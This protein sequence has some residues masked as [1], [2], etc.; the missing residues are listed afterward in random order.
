[1]LEINRPIHADDPYRLLQY[2]RGVFDVVSP[3]GRRIRVVCPMEHPADDGETYNQSTLHIRG[4]WRIEK[5][6]SA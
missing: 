4:W 2:E 6:A 3:A 1:M 5:I